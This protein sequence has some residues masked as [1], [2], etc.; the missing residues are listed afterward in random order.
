MGKTTTDYTVGV[1]GVVIFIFNFYWLIEFG[2][3]W[4]IFTY[5]SWVML[6]VGV[7]L[8]SS[9]WFDQKYIEKVSAAIS[10]SYMIIITL[11][12]ILIYFSSIF[13]IQSHDANM[14]QRS[15]YPCEDLNKLDD[16]GFDSSNE[17]YQLTGNES[18]MD[19]YTK[20]VYL[21]DINAAQDECQ[22]WKELGFNNLIYISGAVFF[23]ELALLLIINNSK[24]KEEKRKIMLNEE[25]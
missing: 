23:L 21:Y 19:N 5:E 18:E 11:I 2:F 13:F 16:F 6:L 12:I 3:K 7:I 4:N 15:I 22:S 24:I 9:L 25:E 14:I 10:S 20:S 1:S 8:S 17:S